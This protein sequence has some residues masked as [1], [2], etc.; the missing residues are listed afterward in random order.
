MNEQLQRP[1]RRPLQAIRR[2]AGASCAAALMALSACGYPAAGAASP[3][4][5]GAAA[6][7]PR[8]TAA[9]PPTLAPDA[10]SGP[11]LTI[12]N[13]TFRPGTLVVAAGTTVTWTNHDDI[14]HTVTAADRSFSSAA[15]DT[16]ER[17]SQR[18]TTPGTYTYFCAIHPRMTGTITVR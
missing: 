10:A 14:P 5:P 16:D 6:S 18:F 8:A 4:A 1:R 12:D 11:Q 2:A 7:P 15:L 9:A 3:P 13:F 17:F